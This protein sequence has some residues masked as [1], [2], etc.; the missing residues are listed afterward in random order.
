MLKEKGV[1]LAKTTLEA[2]YDDNFNIYKAFS[3]S[4][5]K[6]YLSYVS[7]DTDGS[8]QKQSVLLLKVKKIF[9][10]IKEESDIIKKSTFISVKD[11]VFDELLLNI[12][13]FKDGKEIEKIWFDVYKIFEQDEKWKDKLKRATAA[14]DFKNI[15]DNINEKNIKKLYG[16]TLKTSV[17]RLESFQ[18]CP[19]SF[20]LTYGLKLKEK[21]TF[22]LE[23]LD[24]GSF[25]HDVIDSFF[26]EIESRDINLR[27][28]EENE[29]KE[30][31]EKI[32]D[33][34]LNLPRNYIFT[35]SAKFKNQTFRLK[36]LIIK[37]MKYI[38]LSITESDFDV[39]G[40]EVEFG[41]DKKY[42][43][44]TI[45]LNDGKKVEIVG[46]IDRVDIAKD[47]AGRYLRIIDY[48][49]S[50]NNIRLNDV[51]YGLQLQLLTY[52]D[53]A[54]KFEELEPA[55]VLYFNLIEERLDKRKTKEEIE[56]DIK[57]NFRMKGLLVADVKLIRMMDKSL[58]AGPSDIVPAYIKNDETISEQ[59]SS[60]ASK[61]EFKILQKYIIKTIKNISNEILKGNIN[62]RPYYKNKMT[63][64]DY[65]SYKAICQFD[66][67]KFGNEYNYIPNLS[68]EELWEKF[69][70]E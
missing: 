56:Q 24:T 36:R 51:A 33:E 16:D 70:S 54:C 11:A 62:I 19:F 6:L 1:E 13:N 53:A 58:D 35:S 42:P 66:K 45:N 64:C 47:E 10:N 14:L 30:I 65:C 7:A 60:V 63:P 9:P 29:V 17:S 49:S 31:I 69:K 48:K 2:L 52:L 3:T 4:E 18:K 61:D 67:N 38:I 12:R 50:S 39:F 22:K 32:V 44:I 23:G 59:K 28:I 25:M 34:K 5:E 57:K 15:P 20:Y 8:S 68:K 43:P 21:E 40:H 27:E 26:T 41:E 46:K 37:A 55:A